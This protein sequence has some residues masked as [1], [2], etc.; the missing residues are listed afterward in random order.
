MHSMQFGGM[1]AECGKDMTAS[2]TVPAIWRSAANDLNSVDYNTTK[3]DTARANTAVAHI[4]PALRISVEEAGRMDEEAKQ[5]L[6]ND[7]K[8]SLVVDLDLTIIHASVDPTIG[9]WQ[10]DATNPNHGAVSDVRSFELYDD[11]LQR[12]VSYYIK[13]RPHLKDFLKT[14]SQ[15]YELHIYTMGTR[16]YADNI[17]KIVDPDK[18]LFGDRILSRTETPGEDSKNL[19]KIF[20]VD[21]RM[22]VIIDDRADVW[23]W[24]NYLVRVKPFNFFVGI[25]DINSSF[26]P[27]QDNLLDT[28]KKEGKPPDPRVEKV[29][30][31]VL[32]EH[33]STT[34]TSDQ[35]DTLSKPLEAAASNPNESALG[36]M[37]S[38]QEGNDFKSM[39]RKTAEQDENLAAQLNDRPLLQL[40]KSLEKAEEEAIDQESPSPAPTNGVETTESPPKLPQNLLK[41]DDAELLRVRDILVKIQ[42]DFYVKYERK[43]RAFESRQSTTAL[44]RREMQSVTVPDVKDVIEPL[45]IQALRGVYIVFTRMVPLDVN[46]FGTRWAEMAMKLGAIVQTDI[47]KSTTHVIAKPGDPTSKMRKAAARGLKVVSCDWLWDSFGQWWERT[48]ETP[49]LIDVDPGTAAKRKQDEASAGLERD[50]QS[51]DEPDYDHDESRL[52]LSINTRTNG[53]DRDDDNTPDSPGGNI[54]DGDWGDAFDDDEDDDLS[55]DYDSEL[56]P[57]IDGASDVSDKSQRS[58]SSSRGLK[59]KRAEGNDNATPQLQVNGK[60]PGSELQKRKRQALARTSSLTNVRLAEPTPPPVVDP[61]EED[62]DAVEDGVANNTGAADED[63]DDGFDKAMQEAL[64]QQADLE[65]DDEYADDDGG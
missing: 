65:D 53:V 30:G 16:S 64:A 60:E 47:S 10:R 59:R 46:I 9:E 27:N 38:M 36:Q 48:D 4:D 44:S 3:P 54:H 40:Q 17:A 23:K 62:R 15:L 45:T 32:P 51:D 41:D 52:G 29:E 49:Y 34:A 7:K 14:I 35:R 1:C 55:D 63:D 26:L 19:R 18:K 20:P 22:V 33:K 6:L 8:L 21:N 28:L 57:D 11:A 2:V 5:R 42:K 24:S 25:G 31:K 50:K 61:E 58:T 13:L 43:H 56:D 39:E 37:V 12:D